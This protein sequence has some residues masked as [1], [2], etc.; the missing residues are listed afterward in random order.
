MLPDD[1]SAL[2]THAHLTETGVFIVFGL[3][4]TLKT[5]SEENLKSLS[6]C[7][8]AEIAHRQIGRSEKPK[9]PAHF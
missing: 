9:A 5:D 7:G 4:I 1:Q 8:S 6:G 2:Q 3:T